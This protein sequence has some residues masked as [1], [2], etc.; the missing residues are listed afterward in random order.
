M[1][2]DGEYWERAKRG[3]LIT[4]LRRN[5]HPTAPI[6]GEPYC[7]RSQILEYWTTDYQKI[8]IVH[9]HLRPDGTLGLSGRPE[10]KILI[11]NGVFFR[12]LKPDLQV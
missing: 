2:N 5:G 10:P 1:F 4:V 7:T 12:A 3:E 11:I 6:A 8:A 9:Q